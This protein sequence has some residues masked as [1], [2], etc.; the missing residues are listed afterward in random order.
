M[1]TL[2]SRFGRG[3]IAVSLARRRDYGVTLFVFLTAATVTGA[4]C[5][6]FMRAFGLVLAR[7]L[8]PD[9]I[10]AWAWLVTPVA[11]LAAVQAI[12][13]LAPAAEGSGI[14]QVIVAARRAGTPAHAAA[15]WR[16]G[17]RS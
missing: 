3:R 11:F 4:G 9:S 10:G 8:D 12:R 1:I 15:E 13:Q 5:A 7:R 2:R 14:P 6:L 16:Q 17:W